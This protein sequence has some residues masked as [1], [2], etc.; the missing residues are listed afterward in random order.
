[1]KKN[2]VIQKIILINALLI[3]PSVSWGQQAKNVVLADFISTETLYQISSFPYSDHAAPL[4]DLWGW[5]YNGTEYALVCLGNKNDDI[6]GAGLAVVKVA[7][8]NNVQLTKTIKRGNGLN[9]ENG[10]RD[11]RVFG[12][13]AYVSQDAGGVSNYYVNLETALAP[14]NLSNP[15]AGVVDFST[16]SSSDRIHNLHTYAVSGNQALLFLSHLD[17]QTTVPIQAYKITASAPTPSFLRTIAVEPGGFSHDVSVTSNRIYSAEYDEGVTI[18]TYTYDTTSAVLTI[19][20]QYNH[21]YNA[22]RGKNPS[23]F[24]SPIQSPVGHDAVPSTNGLYLF[25]TNERFGYDDPADRQLAAYLQTWDIDPINEPPVSGFRYPIRKVYQVKENSSPGSFAAATFDSLLPGE[26]SNSIHNVQIRNESGS[27]I[28]YVTYYTKGFRILNVANP[29]SPTELGWY[30]TPGVA[31][32]IYP[33]YN[34]SWGVYPYFN[35]GTII[36]SDIDGL[37]IFRRATEVSGTIS[38]NT[39][40]SGAVLIT[41][42]VTVNNNA[43]LTIAAGTTVAFAGWYGI[44]V[45]SGAKII[46]DGTPT[47]TIKFTANTPLA[48][49]GSWGNFTIYTSGNVFDHCTFEYGAQALRLVN[50]GA[51]ISDCNFNTNTQALRL[52]YSNVTAANCEIINNQVAIFLMGQ[53][54]NPATVLLNGCHAKDN[55]RDGITAITYAHGIVKNSHLEANGKSH[56]TSFHGVYV[57]GNSDLT[58]NDPEVFPSSGLNTIRNN[59]GAGVYSNNATVSIGLGVGSNKRGDQAIFG[60]GIYGGTFNGKQVYNAAGATIYAWWTYWG[61]GNCPPPASFFS[62]SVNYAN[63]L[64]TSPT[65]F[66]KATAGGDSTTGDDPQ[67]L[68]M[69]LKDYLLDQS[70]PPAGLESLSEYDALAQYFS[71]IRGDFQDA[72]KERSDVERV[73][74]HVYEHNRGTATGS[75]ALQFL[76]GFKMIFVDLQQAETLC[77][78][79][80]QELAP[81]AHADVLATLI[82]LKLRLGRFTEGRKLFDDYAEAYPEEQVMIEALRDLLST[83]EQDYEFGHKRGLGKQEFSLPAASAHATAPPAR[84]YLTPNFPNP[85]NPETEIRF[86]LPAKGQ[87][88][89]RV[90]NV[91]GVEVRKLVDELLESG[92]HRV[93]WNGKDDAGQQVVSGVYLYRITYRSED[94]PG[95]PITHTGKMSLL[96]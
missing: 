51:A 45:N 5:T 9:S 10:P 2:N 75:K 76:I 56:A 66:S 85:F 35:S 21:T 78:R 79:G 37:Y 19:N 52:E 32:F 77:E 7:D 46:A 6:T 58:F 54:G 23:D 90:Y 1:M 17:V 82:T 59:E 43:T 70:G 14:N 53:S 62:G 15:F 36:V 47:Q 87:V 24:T 81:A 27:D 95:E 65:G 44:T 12:K 63:C 50:G 33:I 49:R 57:I 40:W 92:S 94:A 89:L 91:L 22:R 11:V 3:G 28:A 96:R 13:Y 83:A 67:S 73:L 31:G 71:M 88:T 60:N 26:F 80:L 72:F 8:P 41:G 38:S 93:I 34:G 20:A 74:S 30:D 18:S 69:A 39:T 68:L 42:N 16:Q 64:T 84:F 61:A 4:A 86:A 29:L 55:D 25:S 48:T